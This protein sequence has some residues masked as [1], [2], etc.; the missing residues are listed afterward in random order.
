MLFKRAYELSEIAP[1]VD[2]F[3]NRPELT[4][5]FTQA[6]FENEY[7]SVYQQVFECFGEAET[8]M[9]GL[10]EEAFS[11]GPPYSQDR[12]IGVVVVY[13]SLLST[14]LLRKL[15]RLLVELSEDYLIYIDGHDSGGEQYYLTI[16]KREVLGYAGNPGS[17]NDLGFESGR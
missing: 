9:T 10:A 12:A 8:A 14:E 6:D 7:G 17:L 3:Y 11:M 13:I 15:Q 16:T 1:L 2:R 4:E 5:D